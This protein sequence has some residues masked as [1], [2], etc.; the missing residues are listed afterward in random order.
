MF[1]GFSSPSVEHLIPVLFKLVWSVFVYH[2]GNVVMVIV[3]YVLVL[4]CPK[5]YDGQGLEDI[6]V[7]M[8]ELSK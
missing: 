4:R 3:T 2:I 5:R 8:S 1:W 6:V 7:M